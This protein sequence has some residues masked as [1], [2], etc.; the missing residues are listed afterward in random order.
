MVD[1]RL[2]LEVLERLGELCPGGECCV[3]ELGPGLGSLTLFLKGRSKYVLCAEIDARFVDYLRKRFSGDLVDVVA[4][5]GIPLVRSLRGDCV[6]VSNTPYVVSSRV[7][8]ALVK[9]SIRSAVLVL[10][11]DVARKLAAAPGTREYGRISAFVQTFMKV[12][13]CGRYPPGSFRPRPKVWS[14]VVV[15]ERRRE[16]SEGLRGYEEF[17]KCLFSQRKRVLSRRL[18]EC[19]GRVPEGDLSGMR[20]FNAGP[21]HLLQLYAVTLGGDGTLG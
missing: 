15:L 10:Q 13:V 20:V 17:L 16:W 1:C 18:K 12:R 8:V 6:M 7:V 2:A 4:S 5:D 14:A 11:D 21:D 19:A 9:S 3:Y